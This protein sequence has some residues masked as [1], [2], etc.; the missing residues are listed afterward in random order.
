MVMHQP[1][2]LC[3]SVR[4]RLPAP[5]EIPVIPAEFA[6]FWERVSIVL[7]WAS[8]STPGPYSL[9][10]TRWRACVRPAGGR[11]G[12]TRSSGL[13]Y[14]SFTVDGPEISLYIAA[15][16]P[17][18]QMAELV[19]ALRSGRSSRKGVEVRVLFW[20]PF[21]QPLF[22]AVFCCLVNFEGLWPVVPVRAG[23]VNR[24][25]ADTFELPSRAGMG[26]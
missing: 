2:K 25:F 24:R 26:F 10:V 15:F 9:R 8:P 6:V 13:K 21:I 5:I 1:S 11:G 14:D 12:R 17:R 18:A 20:A 7:A 3:M 22:G 16:L 19:D 23:L 4:F